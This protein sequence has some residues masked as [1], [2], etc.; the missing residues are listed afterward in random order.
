MHHFL[1]DAVCMRISVEIDETTLK[2]AMALTGEKKRSG[3][4]AKAVTEFVR[5]RK[6]KELPSVG[7]VP[8]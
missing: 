2:Q 8:S 3:A 6:A 1:V 7:L 5:R 4:L